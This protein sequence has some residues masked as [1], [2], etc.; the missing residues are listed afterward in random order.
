MG[1]VPA[2][3]AND[4]LTSTLAPPTTTMVLAGVEGGGLHWPKRGLAGAAR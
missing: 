1:G 2:E 4:S 3:P